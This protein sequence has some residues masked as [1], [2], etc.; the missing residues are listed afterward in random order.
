MK[1]IKSSSLLYIYAIYKRRSS[2]F[3]FHRHFS[4]LTAVP[5]L[6]GYIQRTKTMWYTEYLSVLTCP[7]LRRNIPTIFFLLAIVAVY[8]VLLRTYK[9]HDEI[10]NFKKDI[11]SEN[12]LLSQ[13]HFD[14]APR[15]S[16]RRLICPRSSAEPRGSHLSPSPRKVD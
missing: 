10:Q 11:A 6:P 2:V 1:S 7:K 14:S 4:K 3:V 8:E 5:A 9:I 13:A 15:E 16:N 12:E